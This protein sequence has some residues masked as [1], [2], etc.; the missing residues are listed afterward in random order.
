MEGC[1]LGNFPRFPEKKLPEIFLV[2]LVYNECV[3]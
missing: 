1:Q 3:C 2:A